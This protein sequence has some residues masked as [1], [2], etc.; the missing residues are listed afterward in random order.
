MPQRASTACSR[1]DAAA[2]RCPSLAY[3][4]IDFNLAFRTASCGLMGAPSSQRWSCWMVTSCMTV[5][6]S[7]LQLETRHRSERFDPLGI[8]QELQAQGRRFVE[9]FRQDLH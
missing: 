5:G 7:H 8:A 4:R 9:R 1:Q 3:F 2:H 6:R